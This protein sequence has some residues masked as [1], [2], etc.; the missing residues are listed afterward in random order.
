MV[1][2]YKYNS[3]TEFMADYPAEYHYL[4]RHNLLEKFIK[5]LGWKTKKRTGKK[6]SKEECLIDAKNYKNRTQWSNN[7]EI[8]YRTALNNKWLNECFPNAPK[9]LSSWSFEECL[10]E[11]KKYNN[12]TEWFKNSSATYNASIKS[13]WYQEIVELLFNID[14]NSKEYCL[15]SAKQYNTRSEWAKG[16]NS[17]YRNA[18]KND[19][20][21]ECVS[22]MKIKRRMKL[23]NKKLLASIKNK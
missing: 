20:F 11:A 21:D 14:K 22:H 2:K 7:N 4:Y 3:I 18:K 17:R 1:S 6:W 12:K 23:K 19:W 10:E 13:E 9:P 5:E 16:D 15:E 8:A